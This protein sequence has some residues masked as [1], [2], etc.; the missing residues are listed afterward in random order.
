MDQ[1]K[2]GELIRLL[3]QKQ[4]M[5]QLEL[6]EKIGVSDKAVSKWERGC[7]A[8]DL[9]VL[10]I[11][12]EALQVD[13]DA[14]LRGDLNGNN[15]T[16]GNLNKL[17]FYICPDCGNL[18]FSTDAA[19]VNCCGRKLT[20]AQARKA[21]AENALT[22]SVSDGEW[23]ITSDHEMKREHHVSFVAFLTGDMLIVKKLYPEWGLEARLPFFVHGTLLWY[24]T[25]H[26]LF[27]QD[28]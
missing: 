22:V 27:C 26:G 5:T 11:L 18:L 28:I 23:Y 2:I 25:E 9:A 13:A 10:P 16:N 12:S 20:P 21:D 19:D 24:C 7:G 4:G 1:I 15:M 17:K 6:A 14:L 8:P 3:R